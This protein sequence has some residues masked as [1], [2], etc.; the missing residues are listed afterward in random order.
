MSGA[1]GGS[2]GGAAGGAGASSGGDVTA[3]IA[4][5]QGNSVAS[6]KSAAPSL[7]PH[8]QLYSHTASTHTPDG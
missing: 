6:M 2:V 4:S 1:V 5:V 3:V 8:F 7:Y